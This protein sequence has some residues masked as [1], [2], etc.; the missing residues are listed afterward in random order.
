M[1]EKRTISSKSKHKANLKILRLK[2]LEEKMKL[3]I[4]K[5]KQKTEIKKD[6]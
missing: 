5:R 2:K 4:R 6:G 1:T 3:N